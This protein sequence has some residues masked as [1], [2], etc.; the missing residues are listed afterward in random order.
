MATPNLS[1]QKA[2]LSGLQIIYKELFQ[3]GYI[4]LLNTS[5]TEVDEVYGEADGK[6]Y[7]PP[8]KILCHYRRDR[9]KDTDPIKETDEKVTIKIPVKEFQDNE[10]PFETHK[11]LQILRQAVIIFNNEAYTIDEVNTK[12]MVAGQFL[13]MSFDCSPSEDKISYLA[14]NGDIDTLFDNTTPDEPSVADS[15]NIAT[16]EDIDTLFGEDSEFSLATE[17]DIDSLFE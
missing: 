3:Y 7:D 2:F 17:E 8:I 12:S 16:E 4:M 13:V 11:D 9:A 14:A 10:I 6:I 1:V 5:L 15:E